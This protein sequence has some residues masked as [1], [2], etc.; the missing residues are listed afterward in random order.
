METGMRKSGKGV[1]QKW[2]FRESLLENILP[3]IKRAEEVEADKEEGFYANLYKQ[4]W[5]DADLKTKIL[6]SRNNS[7]IRL[8]QI[9]S[10]VPTKAQGPLKEFINDL[11]QGC[12]QAN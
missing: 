10:S 9:A 4:F 5:A 1:A 12:C 2:P 3:A 8:R 6:A 11:L 7:L